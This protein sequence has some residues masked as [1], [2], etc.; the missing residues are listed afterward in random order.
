MRLGSSLEPSLRPASRTSVASLST[1]GGAILG[2]VSTY[3]EGGEPIDRLRLVSVS[4][5]QVVPPV[6]RLKCSV[7]AMV[8]AGPSRSPKPWASSAR[9]SAAPSVV[10]DSTRSFSRAEHGATVAAVLICSSGWS[11]VVVGRELGCR[12]QVDGVLSGHRMRSA[13]SS[14]ETCLRGLGQAFR[15]STFMAHPCRW[16]PAGCRE[17]RPCLAA[18]R[19]ARKGR[20]TCHQPPPLPGSSVGARIRYPNCAAASTAVRHPALSR[21][22]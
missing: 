12:C 14:R 18:G 21:R 1:S 4:R 13:S 10:L 11:V 6:H 22:L 20:L 9:R 19:P 3:D 7:V 2:R 16:A 17:H 15:E 8:T 5:A